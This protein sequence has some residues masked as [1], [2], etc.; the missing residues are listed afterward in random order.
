MTPEDIAIAA[1][2][3]T[4][5]EEFR[6]YIIALGIIDQQSEADDDEAYAAAMG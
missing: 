5:Y 2:S 3:S 4:S 6:R 1:V